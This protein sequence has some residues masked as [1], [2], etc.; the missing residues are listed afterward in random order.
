MREAK[1]RW[2][3]L[4]TA[5]KIF[6]CT[7]GRRDTKVFRFVCELNEPVDPALLQ[8]AVEETVDFFPGFRMVLK[9]GLFWYYLED[10]ALQAAV[11]PDTRPPCSPLYDKEVTGLLFSVTWYSRCINLEVYHA[12]SDG[13][14]A[15]HFLR[16]LVFCY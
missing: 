2:A 8:A 3:Q 16:M 9:R 12:I 14:G 6:P 1:S 7:S 11:Q 10:S 13:T 4:D 5:A 15:M